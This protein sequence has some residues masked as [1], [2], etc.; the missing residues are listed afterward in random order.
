M[1]LGARQDIAPWPPAMIVWGPG[2][3]AAAHR[4]HCVQ[5]LFALR[6]SL[7]VR[8]GRQRT[9]RKCGGAWVRPDATHEMDARGTTLLIAF[10]SAES[11]MGAA[12]SERI[13]GE[14]AYVPA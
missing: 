14:I 6:G 3:A 5:L 12:L 11:D 10:I 8:G 13:D 2:F 4:H 9:W 7:Q 1:P